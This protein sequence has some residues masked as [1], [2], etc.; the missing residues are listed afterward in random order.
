LDIESLFSYIIF[1]SFICSTSP[2]NYFWVLSID[3]AELKFGAVEASH[4]RRLLSITFSQPRNPHYRY[5]LKGYSLNTS[6]QEHSYPKLE[7]WGNIKVPY[8]PLATSLVSL[9][10]NEQ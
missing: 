1:L 4:P 6:N 2:I 9:V 5:N 8:L 10:C 7:T 3:K